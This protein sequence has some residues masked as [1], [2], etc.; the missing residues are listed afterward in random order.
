[1]APIRNDGLLARV[2]FPLY[3]LQTLTNR[4]V[5]VAGGG[6]ASKTGVANGFVSKPFI[7]TQNITDIRDSLALRVT[8]RILL[9]FNNYRSYRMKDLPCTN[10]TFTRRKY[11]S[12]HTMG[13]SLWRKR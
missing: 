13:P 2:D 5:I 12:C 7:I 4:H 11:S 3:T 1:M 6:G 10:L 8:C 9:Q